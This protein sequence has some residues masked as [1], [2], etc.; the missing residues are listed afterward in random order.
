M[1]YFSSWLGK[2]WSNRIMEREK[3]QYTKDIEEYKAQFTRSL[4]QDKSHYSK[5]LEEIKNDLQTEREKQKFI[6]SL[7]F[8]GQF[9]IYNELWIS[10]IELEDCVNQLWETA[11]GKNLASFVKSLQKAKKQIRSSAL[12]IEQ[13]HYEK[14][15]KSFELFEEYKIGKEEL[16][17]IRNFNHVSEYDIGE[18][19]GHNQTAR[20]KILSLIN[21]MLEK[22]RM[23]IRGYN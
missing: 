20:L 22:M 15:I 23:Q 1:L 10:L 21:I 8:E 17:K 5:E 2:V 16:M 19:I 18:L 7:Y 3:A 14:I 12:L 9:K 13:E 4:E 11:S 6:F